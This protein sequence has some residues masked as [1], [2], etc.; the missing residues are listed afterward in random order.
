MDELV[1][2]IVPV[3][4]VEKYL[5]RCIDSI[6]KQTYTN[7]ECILVD[8]GSPDNCPTICDEY[9]KIDSRIKVIHKTNGGLSSARNAGLEICQ[10]KYISFIDSDDW[11]SDIMIETLY[12]AII[13]KKADISICKFIKT[14]GHYEFNQKYI[15]KNQIISY[16]KEESMKLLCTGGLIYTTVCWKLY[17]KSLWNNIYF[18]LG[19]MSEDIFVQHKVF[20]NCSNIVFVDAILYAYYKREGSITGGEQ[21]KYIYFDFLESIMD[22]IAF[23]HNKKIDRDCILIMIRQFWYNFFTCIPQE[24]NFEM[25]Q[26][27]RQLKKYRITFLIYHFQDTSRTFK[28]RLALSLILI[29]PKIYKKLFINDV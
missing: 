23:Y 17:K 13:S 3:Y 7:F 5:N 26:G 28:E 6:L 11:I 24:Y 16:N 29:S 25:L 18:P 27:I 8:D 21:K 15:Q 10:G 9:A 20:Y 19:K 1:S 2:I 12:K 14:S 4:K 22:R